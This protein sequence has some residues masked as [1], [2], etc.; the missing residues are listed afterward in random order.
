MKCNT[1]NTPNY[2]AVITAEVRY[3]RDIEPNAKLLYGEISALCHQEGYCWANNRYFA[4]LYDV[5]NRT[6]QRWLE[7]LQSNNFITIVDQE[8]NGNTQ[9]LIY[10]S[11]AFQIS[12]T[13]QKCHGGT[14]KMSRGGGKN[15]I[16]NTT[17]NTTSI[18]P[19][20]SS[21]QKKPFVKQPSSKKSLRSEE[22]ETQPYSILNETTLPPKD[23]LRLSKEFT[24][25]E[26][27]RAL[28]ISKTQ[29][30]K[31]T[32]MSL[33]LNILQNPDKWPD[34]T[35]AK[36]QTPQQQLAIEYN[37]KLK[38][39]KGVAREP[40]LKPGS[41]THDTVPLEKVAKENDTMIFESN[42]MRIV[43]GG[44]L[45]TVSLR[46]SE[47]TKDIKDAIAHLR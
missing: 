20:L 36:V 17:S 37:E 16:H 5:D 46:S 14:T 9:R 32:L 33:L 34:P 25:A 23:K 31:K 2:Y 39:Q 13:R 10:L 6:V 27:S 40:H 1:Q 15:V 24:E 29:T 12:S 7:S 35:E 26:V 45:T 4:N 21:P 18:N 43:L 44:F 42:A 22:E 38:K 47:F 28:N 19:P 11:H 41:K 30:I 3:C 8:E